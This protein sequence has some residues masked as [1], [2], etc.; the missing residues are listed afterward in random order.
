MDDKLR[1]V[2]WG[3]ADQPVLPEHKVCVEKV[4]AD[5]VL[6]GRLGQLL[7]EEEL[8]SFDHR[9]RRLLARGRMPT[10]SGDWP[11]IPWPAF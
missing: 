4:L 7:D 1:T 2:L 8:R 6:R 10:P 3:W 11:A 5:E 9:C